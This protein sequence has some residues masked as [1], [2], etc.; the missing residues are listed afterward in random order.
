MSL[1]YDL[2][3]VEHGDSA[4]FHWN[5]GERQLALLWRH[6]T[7]ILGFDVMIEK[8]EALNLYI[9]FEGRWCGAERGPTLRDWSLFVAG[10]AQCEVHPKDEHGR[11]FDQCSDDVICPD[12]GR[13]N[14]CALE[15]GHDGPCSIQ[16][17]KK[18]D[19]MSTEQMYY[20]E[21]TR[22]IVGN[23]MLWWGPNRNGY[24]TELDSAGLYTAGQVQGMRPTDVGWPK[25][26]VEVH[27]VKHVRR[28]V[29][30][31]ETVETVQGR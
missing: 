27:V 21:D 6:R 7:V 2:V 18:E 28:D 14:H 11:W 26:F 31:G 10:H 22:S 20:V 16:V 24:T 30:R 8:S 19:D 15:E 3:C 12:C 29:L 5:H 4:G 9:D 25:E 17:D 13:Q 23:C 1:Y